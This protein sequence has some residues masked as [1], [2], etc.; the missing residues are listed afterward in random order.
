VI[1]EN[2]QADPGFFLRIK[3]WAIIGWEPRC[4]APLLFGAGILLAEAID[5]WQRRRKQ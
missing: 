1:N 5:L 4:S 3:K 2:G